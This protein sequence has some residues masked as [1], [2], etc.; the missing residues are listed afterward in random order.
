M[1]RQKFTNEQNH[2][3]ND[4]L[5]YPLNKMR[6]PE[7]IPFTYNDCILIY[8]LCI[9]TTVYKYYKYIQN[10]TFCHGLLGK[11][12]SYTDNPHSHIAH[13]P[14]AVLSFHS[15][16]LYIEVYKKCI[17]HKHMS[18]THTHIYITSFRTD[19][20]FSRRRKTVKIEER[21]VYLTV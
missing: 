21:N 14:Y 5:K 19:H 16:F 12:G 2:Y 13:P 9:Y 11:N 15:F 20:L 18:K 10:S 1:K 4:F 3:K 8:K 6:S 7:N 17:T